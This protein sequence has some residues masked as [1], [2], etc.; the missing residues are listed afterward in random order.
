M[1]SASSAERMDRTMH[2]SSANVGVGMG[3]V[4]VGLAITLL[5]A[6]FLL[7]GRSCSLLDSE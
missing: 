5:G 7:L 3:S 2:D 4:L 6:L 1:D